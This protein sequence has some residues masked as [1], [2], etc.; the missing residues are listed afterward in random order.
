MDA[1]TS[2]I[3]LNSVF[4]PDSLNFPVLG[5]TVSGMLALENSLLHGVAVAV[6]VSIFRLAFLT[7]SL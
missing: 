4:A 6:G 2:A 1:S 3:Q 5:T 7:M